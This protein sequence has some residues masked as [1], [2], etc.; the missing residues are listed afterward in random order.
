[1]SRMNMMG[2]AVFRKKKR[3]IK[4]GYSDPGWEWPDDVVSKMMRIDPMPSYIETTKGLKFHLIP[5]ASYY[6]FRDYVEDNDGPVEI[7]VPEE[8]KLVVLDV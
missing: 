8:Y 1:M 4:V 5:F 7:Y 3:R 2:Q 6:G